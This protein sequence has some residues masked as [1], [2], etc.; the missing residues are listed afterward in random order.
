[1]R[2]EH[3]RISAMATMVVAGLALSACG[4][5]GKMAKYAETISY[6]VQPNPLI[7][8][9][10]SVEVNIDG[11]FPG[12]YFSK[13]AMVELTPVLTY[14]AGETEYET[15]SF[16]GV[17]A[18]GNATVIPYENGKNFTYSD[19][20]AYS[21]EMKD[22][23]LMIH[24][25]GRQGNKEQEFDPYK[26]AEGVIT[27]PYLLMS[28][29]KPI[30]AADQFERTTAH[31]Q[32]AVIHYL[33]NSPVVRSSELRD[34]DIKEMT[35]FLNEYGDNPDYVFQNTEIVA[36]A[37][38][39]GEIS[40]N[41]NLAEERAQSAKQAVN[42]MMSRAGIDIDADSFF[43]LKPKGEDWEGFKEKM[44][45]SDIEDKELI[46]RILEMYPDKKKRE[47]EIRN[48]AAT[49]TVIADKI[50]PDLRRSQITV[51]Y[52]IEGRSDE[53]IIALARGENA[54]TLSVEE[55]LYA[56]TLTDDMNEQYAIYEFTSNQYSDD[57]RAVN[58]MGV[59]HLQR[60]EL[61]DAESMFERSLEIEQ[62]QPAQNNLAI[63]RRLNGNR[64]EAM[65]LL[66]QAV[67][68]GDEVNYNMGIIAI[69]NGHYNEAIT[70]MKGY[71]TFNKALAQV[72][73]GN[74]EA[75]LSTLNSSDAADTAMGYYLKAII[76]ARMNDA[77]MVSTNLDKA[78]GLDASL[79][80]K[81]ADD[82][83][84]R[85]FQDEI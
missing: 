55:M 60:N 83:E 34:T 3:S 32:Y 18:A 57:Y 80:D 47:E 44:Q 5:L 2:M 84:F 11:N 54:D 76:G 16:K 26:I 1:M 66:E 36:Y 29:D 49:Y 79:K 10:D 63:V 22:S 30:L 14:P 82:L 61:A 46:L 74:N 58:N 62:N 39:E 51:N 72:L 69:Q 64:H 27:T 19:K 67:G 48:L 33:V 41:E 12:K 4:G 81:A 78:Y 40:F 24:I 17:D 52:D 43:N 50:L 71:N 7:V 35:S 75:A 53:E 70:N 6:D 9:G 21:P 68:A 8:R 23:D 15:V 13:K 85:N 20:V 45:A 25:L 73:A 28:D 77:G 59:I 42:R 37:S 38:P 56:A 65:D 31:N